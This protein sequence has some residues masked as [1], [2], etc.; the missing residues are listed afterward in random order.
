MHHPSSDAAQRSPSC[1]A[2]SWRRDRESTA[3]GRSC[4]TAHCL[5]CRSPLATR[6]GALPCS[7]AIPRPARSA[8]PRR[9]PLLLVAAAPAEAHRADEVADTPLEASGTGFQADKGRPSG[10]IVHLRA[11]NL[12]SA[13]KSGVR[14]VRR[15]RSGPRV[16]RQGRA[17]GA[18]TGCAPGAITAGRARSVRAGRSG[19]GP[20]R[21]RRGTH[22]IPPGPGPD[23]TWSRR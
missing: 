16:G 11:G 8:I 10:A 14:A 15:A 21:A 12:N 2:T 7:W 19:R 5:A 23:A 6:E 1:P 20:H 4:P 17:P 18:I 9:F 22:A 13:G 3:R